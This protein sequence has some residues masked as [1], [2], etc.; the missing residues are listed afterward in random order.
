MRSLIG[1]TSIARRSSTSLGCAASLYSGWKQPASVAAS[2]S[3]AR[4]GKPLDHDI[5]DPVRHDDHPAARLIIHRPHDG[6]EG[7][8]LALD[9]LLVSL[10]LDR[11]L[12]A[13]LAVDLHD[14]G[15]IS[16]SDKAAVGDRPRALRDEGLVP[17]HLP[18]FFR[19]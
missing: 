4:T 7:Q 3:A 8:R 6:V 14:I 5:D 19:Q 1:A 16:R 13:L 9:P 11:E 17:Q 15:D 12:T 18:A 10:P 2:A